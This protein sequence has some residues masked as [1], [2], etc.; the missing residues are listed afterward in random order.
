MN[1]SRQ[2]IQRIIDQ[3]QQISNRTC[4][5]SAVEIVLKLLGKVDANYYDLQNGWTNGSF[6]NFDGQ[7]L[8]G[9]TFRRINLAERGPTFPF[10]QLFGMID[11]ELSSDRYVIIS[12]LGCRGKDLVSMRMLSLMRTK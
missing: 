4:I 5:P 7:T 6:V 9:V 2:Y 12:L 3:H 8:S 10:D 11:Q 1:H